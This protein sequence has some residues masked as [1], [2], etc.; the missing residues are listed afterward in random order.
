MNQIRI[1]LFKGSIKQLRQ[2][3]ETCRRLGI[4]LLDLAKLRKEGK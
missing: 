3:L 2:D 4:S 1:G